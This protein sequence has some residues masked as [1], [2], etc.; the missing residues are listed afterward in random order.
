M[1]HL[2]V[3]RVKLLEVQKLYMICT[4]QFRM[5]KSADLLKKC[6]LVRC[7]ELAFLSTIL[8]AALLTSDLR[9]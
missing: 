3:T 9:L 4:S 1:Y 8:F 7:C 2:A 6:Q 5:E